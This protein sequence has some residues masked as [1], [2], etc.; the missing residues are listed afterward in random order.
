[1]DKYP[2]HAEL[3]PTWKPI[4][5]DNPP[6]WAKNHKLLFKGDH[7]GAVIGVWYPGCGWNWAC[8]LPKHTDEQKAAIRQRGSSAGRFKDGKPHELD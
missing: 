6:G 3:A 7:S 4:D 5:P 1:M 2:H 8:G